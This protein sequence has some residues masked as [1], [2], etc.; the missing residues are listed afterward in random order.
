MLFGG[1]EGGQG[2]LVGAA[3]DPH[4]RTAQWRLLPPAPQQEAHGVSEVLQGVWTGQQFLAVGG[5]GPIFGWA[6]DPESKRWGVLPATAD[7]SR[8][9]EE[10][11][12]IAWTG[13]HLLV[14]SAAIGERGQ[15][16]TWRPE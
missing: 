11:P 4:D 14:V 7:P 13:E 15:L 9:A 3:I 2:P 8:V 16:L 1:P 5:R 10:P 6:Y 12:A